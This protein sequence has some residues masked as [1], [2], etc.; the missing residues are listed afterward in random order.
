L[1]DYVHELDS[2]VGEIMRT[3]EELKIGDKT[4]VIFT[5][6]NGG[7]YKDFKGTNGV[8]LNLANE[9]GGVLEGF[10][11][12]K[13]DAKKLGHSTN[14]IYRGRKGYPEEGGH[15]VV[16]IA[17]WPEGIPAG[18]TSDYTCMLTDMM[19]TVTD[20]LGVNLPNEA[21]ED[22]ISILPRLKEKQDA[23]KTERTIYV[24]G[25]TKNDAIA[26]CT[27]RWKMIAGEGNDEVP[28]VQ[29]YDL[30]EDPAEMKNVA[31]DHPERVKEMLS[32]LK[33]ARESGRTR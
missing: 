24:Q 29:L 22:S 14:G 3:L 9:E 30:H 7:S 13:E 10:K 26:I 17:R 33:K 16:F 25:D 15:R 1:G 31:E 12:A 27:G 5:S 2:H 23:P 20:M 32:G 11:T 8:K 4:L 28:P 21:G 19:A 6:D 18:T